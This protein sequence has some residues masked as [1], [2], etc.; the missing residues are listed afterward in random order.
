MDGAK[1]IK[2]NN[3]LKNDRALW[4]AQWKEIAD[5]IVFRKTSIV[6]TQTSG[7]KNTKKLYDSTATMAAEDLTAWIHGNMTAMS[8]NWFNLKIRDQEDNKELQA[9]LEE[10]RNIQ[11]DELRNSNFSGEWLETLSDIVT[12]NT[13]GI[14]WEEN[15]VIKAG[16]NGLNFISLAPGSYSIMEGRNGL[17]QGLFREFELRAEEAVAKWGEKVSTDIT[18]DIEKDASKK[19]QFLHAVFPSDW[20]GGDHMTEL[21]YASYYLDTKK[22][23]VMSVGGYDTFPFAVI[24]WRRESGE[25]Y[26][27]GPGWTAL[28]DVKTAHKVGELS[29]KEWA[30][31]IWPPMTRVDQG[32]IGTIRLDPGGATVVKKDGDLKPLSTGARYPDNRQRL[33]D[34]KQS[35]KEVFH[36]DKVKFIPPRE[37]TGQMTAYEVS[38]RYQ[39]AQ[40]LLGPTFG[41]IIFHGLDRI[42]ESTFNM[43]NKAG[44]F[45]HRPLILRTSK[46]NTNRLWQGRRECRKLRRLRILLRP[47]QKWWSSSQTLWIILI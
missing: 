7:L 28:P 15:E 2:I 30:L 29:L 5:N 24:P 33:L 3:N 41:N 35:I 32:V 42:I 6:G 14:F 26:G 27:R 25:S 38:K 21:E 13:G 4:D 1:L 31:A 22:R 37:Q 34:L 46:L 39:L 12:F 23:T 45:P 9:W 8:M 47:L 40:Q 17:I 10:C 19:H 11:L 18:K 20:F 36:N 16:F 43:M 44:A